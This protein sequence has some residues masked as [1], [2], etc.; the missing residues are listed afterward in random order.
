LP[1]LVYNITVKRLSE[2]QMAIKS[3]KDHKIVGGSDEEKCF[4]ESV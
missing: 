1:E 4:E 2:H 3:C